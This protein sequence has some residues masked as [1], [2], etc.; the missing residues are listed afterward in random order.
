VP[1]ERQNAVES[2]VFEGEISDEATGLVRGVKLL[3]IRSRNKRNYDTPGVRR[4]AKVLLEGA[5]VYIDHPET[6]GKPRSYR[7]SFGVVKNVHYREG[8]GH[9]GDLSYNPSHPLANQFAWDVKNN[10]RGLGMSV[11]AFYLRGK[12][13]KDGFESVEGL[14]LIRSVDIVTK[15]ATS[16][17]I[18]ESEDSDIVSEEEDEVMDLKTLKEKHGDLL[19]QVRAEFL[20]EK[21]ETSEATELQKKLADAT[22]QLAALKKSEEDRKHKEAIESEFSELFESV[23]AELDDDLRKNILECA[24]QMTEEA[25]KPY[26][27]VV[28][29]LA[30]LI[31]AA[32]DV[33]GDDEP[34]VAEE[35]E[36]E[37]SDKKPTPR[38]RPGRA[39]KPA[40]KS[41]SF[42]LAKMLGVTKK[43]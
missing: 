37:E 40:A 42:D 1:I 3:G 33:D 38:Y 13:G 4:T 21:S 22:E 32:E 39:G 11:N 15:P 18:F 34:I 9:F 36:E 6:P 41:G 27:T 30:K 24:C 20:K 26:R 43:S 23:E 16:E 12:I 14:E 5:K 17:G 7:D 19:E 2:E 25:R 28:E 35:Q 8:Q 29:A 31:P 10:P